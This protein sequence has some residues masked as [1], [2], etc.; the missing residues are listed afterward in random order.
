[1]SQP[2]I[3][4]LDRKTLDAG[5]IAFSAL[6]AIGPVTYHEVTRP[7][8]IAERIATADI[9]LTNKVIVDAAA[10]DAAPDLKL[11]QVVATGVNNVD[12]AAARERGIAV[13]NVS[14]YSTPSVAQHTFALI[15]NL[16]T[17]AHRYGA[18]A[19]LWSASPI[20]T[21]LDHPIAELSGR[22]LGIAGLGDIGKAVAR[23][24]EAFGMR[25]I[26]LSRQGMVSDPTGYDR[27]PREAFFAESDVISLH[28][29]LT[30]DTKH[31]IREETLAQMKS[32][33]ILIN[34]GRGPLIDE[35][36][37]I[38]ALRS[39]R[40]AGAG[41]DVLSV[42]PPAPDHPLLDPTIP[43]LLVTP[44]TAWASRESRRRLLDRVV[45]NLKAFLEGAPLSQV[46]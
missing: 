5:D 14:G 23:I 32:T 6:E 13:C 40:I 17:Q 22:T 42:E 2:R 33:A 35:A 1:M 31:L 26:G 24:G 43:N 20:F 28:C 30:D 46:N 34:T 15:L 41:L 7:A 4:F 45:E 27:L 12:L 9:A 18:E 3:V 44:H 11:I 8:E 39:G 29:P 19:A 25:V 16:M 21:R 38:D 36:A 37:L 10:M